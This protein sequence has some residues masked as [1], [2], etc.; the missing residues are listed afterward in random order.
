MKIDLPSFS[1]KLD[2]EAFLDWIKNVED[3]F[4]YMGTPEGKKVKLV[5]FKLK[6]RAS[7]WWDQVQTN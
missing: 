2:L 4:E 3:F 1:G 5:S 6:S 7:A